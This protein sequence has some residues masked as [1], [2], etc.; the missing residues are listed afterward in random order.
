MHDRRKP[1]AVHPGGHAGEGGGRGR[2][3]RGGG[4]ERRGEGG[5]GERGGRGGEGGRR[6]ERGGEGG[7]RGGR[8]G[9]GGGGGGE[10]RGGG[11]GGEGGGEGGGGRG[12]ERDHDGED[13]GGRRGGTQGVRGCCQLRRRPAGVGRRAWRRDRRSSPRH[14]HRA[15]VA[16]AENEPRGPS[17][18]RAGGTLWSAP[19]GRGPAAATSTSAG[20]AAQG[21]VFD[22]R[23]STRGRRRSPCVRGAPRRRS[24]ADRSGRTR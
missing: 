19:W 12:G 10:G 16:A 11:G 18:P 2:G 6:E 3:G 15:P 17:R 4:G 23:L 24:G 9:G 7:G 14:R 5:G 1:P 13:Q 20:A 21:A 22:E 8:G